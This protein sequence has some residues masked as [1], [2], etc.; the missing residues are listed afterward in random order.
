[1]KHTTGKARTHR[2][3]RLNHEVLEVISRTPFSYWSPATGDVAWAA[4]YGSREAMCQIHS[5]LLSTGVRFEGHSRS[6][7]KLMP[8][9]QFLSTMLLHKGR[10]Q[11]LE[12]SL[13]PVR[14][15]EILPESSLPEK[16]RSIIGDDA[17]NRIQ[18]DVAT[19]S[20]IDLYRRIEGCIPQIAEMFLFGGFSQHM[21]KV[22]LELHAVLDA[23]DGVMDS[24]TELM[25]DLVL[26]HLVMSIP[27]F[28]I[29]ESLIASRSRI[30]EIYHLAGL[31]TGANELSGLDPQSP[32]YGSDPEVA[33]VL[34]SDI[35]A[36]CSTLR[37]QNAT[38][39]ADFYLES[40]QA[41]L[42]SS[43]PEGGF[44]RA[45]S[46]VCEE[47]VIFWQDALELVRSME[48]DATS[49]ARL[50]LH[51]QFAPP[52]KVAMVNHEVLAAART[53]NQATL[54]FLESVFTEETDEHIESLLSQVQQRIAELAAAPS[55]AGY[56]EL[57]VLSQRATELTKA[58]VQLLNHRLDQMDVFRKQAEEFKRVAVDI[59]ES[60][61][62]QPAA[63]ADQPQPD[64]ESSGDSRS[65]LEVELLEANAK[66]ETDLKLARAE[67]HRLMSLNS[68][69]QTRG[70]AGSADEELVDLVCRKTRGLPL[71]PVQIL[72]Y[73][74][75]IAP[76]RVE[77]LDSAWKTAKDSA[78]FKEPDRLFEMLGRLV[79]EYLDGVRS[80]EA[81]G[82]LGIQLFAG[83]FAAKESLTVQRDVRMR[84][85]REFMYRGESRFFEY[86]LRIANGW[87]PVEGMRLYFDVLDDRLVI[88][89]VGEHLD[90][91]GTN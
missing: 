40:T 2:N 45:I 51:A 38:D 36:A 76:D 78:N 60:K 46:A 63:P 91:A 27:V 74:Q 44:S 88:A 65:D 7:Q 43:S 37:Y 34:A 10:R 24:S 39:Y 6:Q 42:L 84:A 21:A 69:L 79:F 30:Q 56:A 18:H 41:F 22:A 72:R 20:A 25:V 87:G 19:V 66:L 23:A 61:R 16:I 71:T 17:Y 52:E 89:Y 33:L 11:A 49:L 81:M 90:Q 73:F 85:Q 3:R 35:P 86:R 48:P 77:I 13:G 15:S 54:T 83:G 1:M 58:Q 80:G 55:A 26:H 29:R 59:V 32:L 14:Y 31:L 47:G 50:E 64:R 67:N 5:E 57:G 8:I 28:L 82:A 9:G 12:E 70:P 53:Y 62:P 4:W 68:G 75:L